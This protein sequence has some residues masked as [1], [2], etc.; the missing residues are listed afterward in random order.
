MTRTFLS[1]GLKVNTVSRRMQCVH[2]R[3]GFR[4]RIAQGN[5]HV[6]S[7]S[8]ERPIAPVHCKHRSHR[9][10]VRALLRMGP[11]DCELHIHFSDSAFAGSK[12]F[13]L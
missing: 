4:A 6:V 5:D 10:N 13:C 9:F 3:I 1:I 11:S 8:P 7:P 12:K 2:D